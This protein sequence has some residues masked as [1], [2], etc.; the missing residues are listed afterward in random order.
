MPTSNP[1]VNITFE[2]A[3]AALLAKLANAEHKSVAGLAKELILEALTLRED[4]ALS[5]IAKLREKS[6]NKLLDHDEV[7]K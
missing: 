3:T 6:K 2:H 4:I 7:W 1:R 5:A